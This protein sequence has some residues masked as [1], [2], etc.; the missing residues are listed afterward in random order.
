MFAVIFE[1][2]PRAEA[3][4]D[5]LD[6]AA[7]LRPDLVGM[8]GFIDN[9]RFGSKTRQ[10]WLVSLSLWRDEKSVI[11]WRTQTR[12]HF[13][14]EA[15]RNS[16]F[17]DYRLRVGEVTADSGGDTAL[18]QQ[19]FDATETSAFKALSLTEQPVQTL[20]I[21]PDAAEADLFESI[22]RPGVGLLLQSWPDTSAAEAA[23]TGG[24]ARTRVVR[25][26]RDY[27]MFRREEAPQYYPPA[28]GS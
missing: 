9:E 19:R 27:G 21:P 20:A 28:P 4:Q 24:S 7:A 26:I 6:R 15:G 22:T 2:N 10:G 25:V 8:E 16:V 17:A 11:R 18:P 14:Q 3:W 5:Y 1:V 23:M 13:T 12:H